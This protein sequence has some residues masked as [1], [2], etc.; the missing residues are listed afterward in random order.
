MLPTTRRAE[1]QTSFMIAVG[2]CAR[3]RRSIVGSRDGRVLCD[4]AAAESCELRIM[5]VADQA[6][7]ATAGAGRDGRKHVRAPGA[8]GIRTYRALTHEHRIATAALWS[9]ESKRAARAFLVAVKLVQT[10]DE[11]HRHHE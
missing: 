5:Q 4:V 3:S 2:A 6:A 11:P 9:S 7:P 1:E 10:G 8:V